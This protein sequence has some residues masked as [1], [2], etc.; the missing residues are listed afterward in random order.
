ML[1]KACIFGYYQ[2]SQ[3]L[4]KTKGTELPFLGEVHEDKFLTEYN[5]LQCSREEWVKFF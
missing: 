3:E 4:L 2:T 1:I 5:N